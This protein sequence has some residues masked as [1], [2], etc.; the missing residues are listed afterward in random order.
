MTGFQLARLAL[1]S[2]CRLALVSNW[3]DLTRLLLICHNLKYMLNGTAHNFYK[4]SFLF[5]RT[6][7]LFD[8]KYF[9]VEILQQKMCGGC[10]DDMRVRLHWRFQLVD[11]ICHPNVICTS[12]AAL[13][14]VSVDLNYLSTVTGT[15]Y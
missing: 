9:G 6:V 12:S 7:L 2:N 1:V 15:G 3:R 13:L 4:L 5:S 14:I 8:W 11:D 10:V